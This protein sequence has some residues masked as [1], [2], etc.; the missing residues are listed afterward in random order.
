LDKKGDF[1]K[2][3]KLDFLFAMANQG[4]CILPCL[5]RSP[6]DLSVG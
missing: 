1:A 5:P 4:E 2:V 6:A 3:S